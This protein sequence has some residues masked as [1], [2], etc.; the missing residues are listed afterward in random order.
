MEKFGVQ[1]QSEVQSKNL[2][3]HLH[4]QGKFRLIPLSLL[5]IGLEI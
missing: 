4:P 2:F 5:W 3:I 1:T